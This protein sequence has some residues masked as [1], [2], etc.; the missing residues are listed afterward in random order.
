LGFH[1]QGGPPKHGSN[2]S[3]APSGI[4]PRPFLN[5][6][7]TE[8]SESAGSN[9]S[10]TIASQVAALGES[11]NSFPMARIWELTQLVGEQISESRPRI[12]FLRTMAHQIRALPAR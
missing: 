1:K 7:A 6:M 5:R 3:N 9:A 11:M 8:L 2:G 4:V 10:A 12:R